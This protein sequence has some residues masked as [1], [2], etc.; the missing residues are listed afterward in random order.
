MSQVTSGV[1]RILAVP[2]IYDLFINLVGAADARV[3]WAREYLRPFPGARILDIGCGTGV[4][5]VC[6]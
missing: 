2:G 6:V 3:R 4:L 1:R 5:V